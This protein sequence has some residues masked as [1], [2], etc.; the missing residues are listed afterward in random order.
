MIAMKARALAKDLIR[1]SVLE[2]ERMATIAGSAPA[3]RTAD[4]AVQVGGQITING[5]PYA[6]SNHKIVVTRLDGKV[7]LHFFSLKKL[8]HEILRGEQI[9]LFELLRE[10]EEATS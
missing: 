2:Q 5:E 10:M 8:Y 3:Y 4:V 9:S 7:C 6:L 1:G